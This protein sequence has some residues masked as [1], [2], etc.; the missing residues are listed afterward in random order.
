[1]RYCEFN[2]NDFKCQRE[3][4]CETLENGESTCYIERCNGE[5][6]S[7]DCTETAED[8][9][10]QEVNSDIQI[11]SEISSSQRIC[12]FSGSEFTCRHDST[13]C[14]GRAGFRCSVDEN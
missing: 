4:G 13:E 10:N 6:H 14:S 12:N 5:T 9:K 11:Q 3:S 2:G 8:S 1:M 7:I